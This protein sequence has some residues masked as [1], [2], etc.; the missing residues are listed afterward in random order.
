M[1]VV[2]IG[3]REVDKDVFIQTVANN[4]SLTHII[5]ALGFNPLPTS[6]RWDV[7]AKI[8]EL[9][10]NT[11]HLKKKK[12][13]HEEEVQAR[14]KQFNLSKDN[15]QYYDEFLSS[16]TERSMATY[17]SSIGNFMEELKDQDFVTISKE[18][19]QE[20]ASTKKTDSMVKNVTAHIR[21]MMIYLV[22]N[23]INNAE[24]KVSKDMLIWLIRK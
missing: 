16:I 1:E 21:S 20:F 23:N 22:V 3:K 15:Q 12:I 24:E 13:V 10:L 14:V 7:T 9:G 6:T 4:K 2:K 17:K 11:D 19:I 18:Q 5:E 8:E